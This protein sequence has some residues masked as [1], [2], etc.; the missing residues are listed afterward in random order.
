MIYQFSC[1][2][3]NEKNK[4]LYCN[5]Q[6]VY[7]TKKHF[8]LLL[9]LL[10]NQ[11][12]SIDKEQLIEQVWS[13]RV[14]TYNSVDQSISK[15]RKLLNSCKSGE[16]IKSV[17]GQGIRFIPEVVCSEH[18]EA[19]KS[20]QAHPKKAVYVFT[21]VALVIMI[22][23]ALMVWDRLA[24]S[25]P[26]AHDQIKKVAIL[27][28]FSESDNARNE[29]EWLYRGGNA[30]LERIIEHHPKIKIF[31][32]SRLDTDTKEPEKLALELVKSKVSFVVLND[33]TFN[34]KEYQVISRLRDKDGIV[35]EITIQAENIQHVM[36][37]LSS[38]VSEQVGAKH[39]AEV[40]SKS[41]VDLTDDE[42]ALQNYMHAMQAQLKGDSQKAVVFLNSAVEQDPEFKQ[43]W[44]ELAIAY[45][46]LGQ[47]K[48]SLSILNALKQSS[49]YLQYRV[50][51]VKGH[52][53]D[54]MQQYQNALQ[55]Y[56][57]S[58]EFAEKISNQAAKAAIQL[59]QA[60]TYINLG[61][62]SMAG[63]LLEKVQKVTNPETEAHFYGVLMNNFAKLAKAERHY[64]QAI[65]YSNRSIE[66]FKR[67]GDKGYEMLSKTRLG[68]LLIH[69]AQFKSAEAL[70]RESL[71][72]SSKQNKPKA[73]LS[74][75]FKLGLIYQNTGLCE[76]SEKQWLKALEISQNLNLPIEQAEIY[77]QLVKLFVQ[78]GQK[79]QVL[80]YQHQIQLLAQQYALP[81]IAVMEDSVNLQ[82]A[83]MEKDPDKAQ[84]LLEKSRIEDT[85]E[86]N[87][88]RG[89][90]ARLKQQRSVAEQYYINSLYDRKNKSDYLLITQTMNSLLGLYLDPEKPQMNKASQILLDI[91]A[92]HPVAYPFLKY[93]AEFAIHNGQ[94]LKAI[95]LLEE[96]KQ[97][98]LCYWLPDDQLRL[99]AMAI[100]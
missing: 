86:L 32:P 26:R 38:W 24:E 65:G 64:D 71:Y 89:D 98:N 51:L 8:D 12:K 31:K 93:Q 36:L 3:L 14:V 40:N 35:A 95:S 15:L 57:L 90:L 77:T 94:R 19:V 48:K 46:K 13:G 85:G 1:F 50:Q 20:E 5:G 22:I 43:A 75:H 56:H 88:Y 21:M 97:T 4:Q 87:L 28:Y 54:S 30:Y 45:R 99:E 55:A 83:L 84:A 96:L 34:G 6:D 60:I 66:A 44:Y 53:Y 76:K 80:F 49:D 62:Y 27:P 59:S 52:T 78:T 70:V 37:S 68:S 58:Y 10:K 18:L 91:Q 69:L 29:V 23:L 7:L 82:I 74:N 61:E 63:E 2:T 73:T 47:Y 41:L 92:Y 79:A 81:Q 42:F 33:F 17:Y 9:F 25:E 16:Y 11:G 67:S 72:Y 39:F 100:R